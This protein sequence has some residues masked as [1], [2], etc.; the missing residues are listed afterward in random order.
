MIEV[1]KIM[2]GKYDPEISNIFQHQEQENRM[3][4]DR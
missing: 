2:S 4:S 1:Y 3:E